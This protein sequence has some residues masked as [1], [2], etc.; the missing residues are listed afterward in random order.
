M[1]TIFK[2]IKTIWK[3]L[4]TS[5]RVFTSIIIILPLL[6]LLV[7]VFYQPAIDVPDGAAL[8]LAPEG[9]IVEHQ[10]IMD[11]FT[12]LAGKILGIPVQ[13]ETPLQDILD[14]I[15]A[16]A[17]DER[18][19][20][21]VI[22]PAKIE[23]ISLSQLFDIGQAI[24]QFKAS[25]KK[26]IAAADSF[27]Q[28]Q[29]YLAS[30]AD[31]IFMNPMGEVGLHGFGMYRLYMKSLL[32]KLEIQFHTFTVGTY[33]SAL[34][35]FTRNDMSPAAKEANQQWLDSLWNLFCHDIA[36]QR[37]LTVERINNLVNH[38]DLYLARNGGDSAVTA[39]NA[40]LIDG[41]KDRKQV[42][43]YL[44]G[45]MG[46]SDTGSGLR[47]ISFYNYMQTIQPSYTKRQEGEAAVAIIIAQGNIVVENGTH[48]QIEAK[49]LIGQ[50]RRAKKD[51][52]IKALVLRI[53]SGGGSAF[54]SEQIRQ[55]LA[56]FRNT[57]K[58]LIISMASMAAS[59]AYWLSADAD[60]IMASPVTLTGSIGIFGAMPTIDRSLARVGIYSDGTGTTSV[61]GGASLV[62]PLA[63]SLARA[64]QL[65]VEN[66]YNKFITIVSEGRDMPML[67]VEAAAQGRIWEG[68]K[69][70]ELGLIDETGSLADAVERAAE[71]AGMETVTGI[72]IQTPGG[73]QALV[74]GMRQQTSVL[75]R[76]QN[77]L[78]SFISI[79]A[80]HGNNGLSFLMGQHDPAGIYA[81]SLLPPSPVSF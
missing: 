9:I 7:I 15:K 59:G 31:E 5:I 62:R 34:E 74:E 46:N 3:I 32:D 29:Y 2:I 18:I 54:A 71:L 70:K 64:T 73:L 28:A 17:V 4:I 79:V 27:N 61:A 14:A 60:L 30:H 24:E 66:I 57:G 39:L 55:E 65:K 45:L 11:P 67:K 52:S 22:Y 23:S 6:I 77:D 13:I 53:D 75:L 10:S 81:H 8:I 36:K 48:G 44:V 78:S 37:G 58:P 69:A 35:P 1:K 26:V 56:N 16:A 41:L 21:M 72:Y 38:P 68:M 50:I 25:G 47:E 33:K 12:E 76:E 19:K 43:E 49:S 51:N 80:K 42:E 20:L 40:G 63:P